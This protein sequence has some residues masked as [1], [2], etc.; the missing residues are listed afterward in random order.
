M[1][2]EPKAPNRLVAVLVY[3]RLATFE[4][5]VA[6]EIFGLPRPEMGEDWYRM[7]TCA[8]E[9]G[10]L[11]AG[12]GLHI[13]AQTGLEGL[14]AAG[15]VIVPGWTGI[16]VPVPQR[17]SAA[18]R[19]ASARGARIVSICSGAFVL[20]AAGLLDGRRATTHWR[21]VDQFRAAFPNVELDPNVLYVDEGRTLTSAGSAA[22]I[23]LMLH[24]VR[25]DFGAEAANSVARRL[26]V[27]AHRDGG[28]AQFIPKPVPK[29]ANGRLAPLLD[30]LR[31]RLDRPLSVVEMASN[32]A[33]SE[34]TFL[35]RFRELTGLTPGRWLLEER[36]ARAKHL[37][38]GSGAS[39]ESVADAAGFGSA[40][41]LRLHFRERIGIG[42]NEYRRR[43]RRSTSPD[44]EAASMLHG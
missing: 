24:I 28:Q 23:D 38:E 25:S 18:L 37:L 2:T 29:V 43:F 39:I 16:D 11:R 20:A 7:V 19:A 30:E 33:M 14:E 34:R 26:V 4:F 1:P 13:T 27:P 41:T 31:N 6:A 17:L 15:T 8:V 36:L 21:Y 3:D 9:P 42:P 10:P 32:A 22:G 12:G 44:G 5:G 35:R 40:A